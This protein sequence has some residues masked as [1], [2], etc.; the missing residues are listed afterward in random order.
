MAN[1][2]SSRLSVVGLALGFAVGALVLYLMV[3]LGDA[4]FHG[5][6][7]MG[8]GMMMGYGRGS[9]AIGAVFVFVLCAA[10]VGAVVAAIHNAVAK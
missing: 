10:I 7:M 3:W 9:W 5:G 1:G 2:R 4:L 8:Q 6:W